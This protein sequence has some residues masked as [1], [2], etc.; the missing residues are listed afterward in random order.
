MYFFKL[1]NDFINLITFIKKPNDVQLKISN[2]E[3]FLMIFNLII[4]EIIFFLLFVFPLNYIAEKFITLKQSEAFENLGWSEGIFLFVLAAPV[5][6]EWVFRYSLRYNSLFSKLISREKWN[7]IFPFLVYIFS[8]VFGFVHLDNY[9]NDSWKFYVLSPLIVASQ[10]SGGLVLSYIRVR[11]N[12]FYSMVYH[13]IWNLLFAI[14]I[15]SVMAFLINPYIDHGKNYD[16]KIE[17][18]VFINNNRPIVFDINGKDDKIYK[19]EIKQHQLQ[20]VLD[21]IYG[22]E[23]YYTDEGLINIYFRSEDGISKEEFLKILQKEY[24]IK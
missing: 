16:L 10:L 5:L 9:I 7:K 3:K 23:K 20:N 17:H 1:R 12:I 21:H 13:A 19:V 2:K 22:K 8:S 11:L 24:D 6:E 14:I 15:P 4:F 18:Q